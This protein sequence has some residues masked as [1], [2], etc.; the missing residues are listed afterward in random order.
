MLGIRRLLRALLE[1][2]GRQGKAD[3]G[4][5]KVMQ[6]RTAPAEAAVVEQ[7]AVAN[8]RVEQKKDGGVHRRQ[9]GMPAIYLF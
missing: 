6:C 5:R 8:I 2:V 4:H 3:Y 1:Q 7:A 9:T